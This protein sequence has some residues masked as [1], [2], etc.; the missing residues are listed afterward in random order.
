M[1]QNF[2]PTRFH[3]K[4]QEKAVA[5]ELNGKVV[6]NSGA[7]R[8]S[9]GDVR[10]TDDTILIEC[11]TCTEKRKSFTI[12]KEWLEKNQEEAFAMGKRYSALA[13]DFGDHAEQYYVVNERI[14][15]EWLNGVDKH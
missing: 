5:K 10:S 7:T 15:K 3:S 11:K 14:F 6:A 13:I 9:K 8:F 1:A 12:K 4:N 2:R